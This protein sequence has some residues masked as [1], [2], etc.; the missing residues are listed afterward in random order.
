MCR[1][2]HKVVNPYTH[3]ELYVDCGC[4]DACKQ[5]KAN[6]VAKRISL[7]QYGMSRYMV[8]LFVHLTYLN[9]CVPYVLRSDLEKIA[10]GHHLV[11]I[12]VY[13]DYDRGLFRA[14]DK[15]SKR[16]YFFGFRKRL[17]PHIFD[18]SLFNE[19]G[20]PYLKEDT[21]DLSNLPDLQDTYHPRWT[22][23]PMTG[24]IGIVYTKDIQNFFKKLNIYA[25]RKHLPQNTSYHWCYEY[26]G[27]KLRPHFHL[28]LWVPRGYE[29][30]FKSAVLA[31]WSYAFRD[32]ISKKIQVAIDPAGYVA[33]YVSKSSD[34]PAILAERPFRQ[35]YS[36]S[37]GFASTLR[38]FRLSAI[39]DKVRKGDL[40]FNRRIFSNGT[41]VDISSPY[42]SFII[43]RYFPKF[44]GFSRITNDEIR[45]L[46]QWSDFAPGDDGESP[47]S[48][49][50]AD[51]LTHSLLHCNL[52]SLFSVHHPD[53][54]FDDFDNDLSSLAWS[55][56]R[57]SHSLNMDLKTY[58]DTYADTWTCHKS[59]L[60]KFQFKNI[61][62]FDSWYMYDNIED[63]YNGDILNYSLDDLMKITPNDFVYVLDPNDFP[64]NIAEDERLVSEFNNRTHQHNMN[65]AFFKDVV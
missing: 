2:R 29:A 4:C 16:R 10:N 26:G 17:D 18:I 55:L 44:K 47:Q 51:I 63:Y 36:E 8:P 42:P 7:H 38:D 49:H 45:R 15:C 12:P 27:E 13:R 30:A 14:S 34:F 57:K 48:Q 6:K 54:L 50:D 33:S 28:L 46:Y 43:S 32:L 1:F 21:Y 31:C 24:K 22:T 65:N 58:L 40:T 37:K 39:L 19:K 61:N 3:R 53:V 59:T 35:R 62:P 56:L 20:I 64:N 41:P 5:K 25:K 11:S 23:L 60:L 52:K 9:E